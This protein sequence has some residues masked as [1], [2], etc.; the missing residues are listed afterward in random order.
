MADLLLLSIRKQLNTV[1]SDLSDVTMAEGIYNSTFS[2]QR[3]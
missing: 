1:V 3:D 2:H